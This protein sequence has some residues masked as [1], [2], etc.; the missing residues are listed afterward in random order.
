M[1][2]FIRNLLAAIAVAAIVGAAACSFF[3]LWIMDVF[4]A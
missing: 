4:Y 3:G 2:S 1:G